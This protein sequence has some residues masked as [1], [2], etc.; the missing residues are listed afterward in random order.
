MKKLLFWI[1]AASLVQ[2]A[3]AQDAED[4]GAARERISAERNQVETAFRI[5]EKACYSRFAVNDCLNAARAHRR[6]ALADLKRQETSLNDADRKRKGAERQRAIE[7][8]AAAEKKQPSSGQ[9]AKGETRQHSVPQPRSAQKEA[10]HAQ[11]QAANA[12]SAQERKR[13]ALLKAEEKKAE[14]ARRAQEAAQ[15]AKRRQEQ[16]EKADEHK[17]SVNKRLAERTKPPAQ[18]LPPPP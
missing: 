4:P 13:Q 6:E 17:A 18:P 1:A 16:Q 12:A 3:L 8:K 2:V 7:E 14:K 10:E 11:A 5:Q 9:P 15:N